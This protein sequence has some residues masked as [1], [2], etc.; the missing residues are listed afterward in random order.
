MELLLNAADAAFLD[1]GLPDIPVFD[2][3]VV[4]E[5]DSAEGIVRDG[6]PSLAPRLPIHLTRKQRIQARQIVLVASRKMLAHEPTI[7]YTQGAQRWEGINQRLRVVMHHHGD[8]QD[9]AI[10]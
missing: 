5:G 2:G 4:D 8:W 1:D 3:E 7:H 10:P 9:A 6:P